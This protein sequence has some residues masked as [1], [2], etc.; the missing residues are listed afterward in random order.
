MA[1]PA[2]TLRC[3]DLALSIDIARGG[4]A[5]SLKLDGV[6]LLGG[7]SK[8]PVENGMYPMGPWAGRLTDNQLRRDGR[9]WPMPRNYKEWALHGTVLDRE[10]VVVGLAQESDHA[11]CAISTDLGQT[12]PWRGSMELTWSLHRSVLRTSLSVRAHDSE[13]PAVIGMHPWLRKHTR[14][15]DAQWQMTAAELA[16]KDE[17][18]Q[19]TGELRAP[20]TEHGSFDDCFRVADHRARV[21]WGQELTLEIHQSH[22]WFVVY[23]AV[24]DYLCVEPQTGPPN[25]VNDGVFGPVAMVTP[26]K[27]LSQQTAWSFTRA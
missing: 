1:Q 11:W 4:R 12:W 14:F 17:R 22:S 19:L 16:V 23:D 2:I 8:D 5:T 9:D 20:P 21:M 24:D 25:G 3:G 26:G 27:P 18:L 15:G 13:F 10:W 6:E 7:P